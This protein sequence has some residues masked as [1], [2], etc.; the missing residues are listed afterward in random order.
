MKLGKRNSISLYLNGGK[1][2]SVAPDLP[3]QMNIDD[4][5]KNP[6]TDGKISAR[7][8]LKWEVCMSMYVHIYLCIYTYMCI[9]ICIHVY[10]Y[11]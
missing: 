9:Y 1:R 7:G 6:R 10:I 11:T 4:H 2:N 3:T 5:L 8:E